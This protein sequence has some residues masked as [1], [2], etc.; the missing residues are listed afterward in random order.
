VPGLEVEYEK[1]LDRVAE[2]TRDLE[3]NIENHPARTILAR[4]PQGFK[5]WVAWLEELLLLKQAGYPFDK[6]DL[7]VLEWKGLAILKNWNE[8]KGHADE[9]G[10]TSRPDFKAAA[11]GKKQKF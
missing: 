8:N 2:E 11:S 5:A 6:D 4:F 3:W 1:F 7:R 10:E 9:P